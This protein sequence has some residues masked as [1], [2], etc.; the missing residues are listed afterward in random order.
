MFSSLCSCRNQSIAGSFY[1]HAVTVASQIETVT[2]QTLLKSAEIN[3]WRICLPAPEKRS[4]CLLVPPDLLIV[5]EV[6]AGAS[7]L[8]ERGPEA[9]Y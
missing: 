6:V 2:L 9:I 3:R 5:F 4:S 8:D 7:H 1:E